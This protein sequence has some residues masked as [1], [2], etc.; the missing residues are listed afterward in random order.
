METKPYQIVDGK[1]HPIKTVKQNSSDSE[2]RGDYWRVWRSESKCY[3]EYDE[4]HFAT[5]MKTIEIS[6]ANFHGLTS[7][8]TSVAN[9]TQQ[10]DNKVPNLTKKPNK[11]QM[12]TPMKPSD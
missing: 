6:E 1:F 8:T 7:G 5:K 9:V 12:A 4:G 11:T 2:F 10:L 3:L